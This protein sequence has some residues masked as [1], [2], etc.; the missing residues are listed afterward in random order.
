MCRTLRTITPTLPE[1]F[2]HRS[3]PPISPFPGHI[4]LGLVL[5]AWRGRDCLCG[6]SPA[7]ATLTA[8]ELDNL[9]PAQDPRPGIVFMSPS[10]VVALAT[11][12]LLILKRFVDFRE[13]IKAIG[14]APLA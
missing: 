3:E 8:V 6:L 10:L 7:L 11:L 13:A 9:L 1:R 4:C 2:P 14:Y 5:L 12:L